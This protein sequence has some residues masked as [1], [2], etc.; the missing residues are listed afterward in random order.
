MV[1]NLSDAAK[2]IPY[3]VEVRYPDDQP[4]PDLAESRRAV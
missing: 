2:L 4:K 1:S 3:G